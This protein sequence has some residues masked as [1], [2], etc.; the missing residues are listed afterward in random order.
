[1]DGGAQKKLYKKLHQFTMHD[2]Y[3]IIST[4]Y[5]DYILC[6]EELFTQRV[7][8]ETITIPI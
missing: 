8:N 2:D 6:Y 4:Y 7:P 1:M 3:N 5:D